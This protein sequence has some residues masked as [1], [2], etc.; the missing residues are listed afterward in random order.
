MIFKT[1]NSEMVARVFFNGYFFGSIFLSLIALYGFVS[2]AG[3]LSTLS[4][5]MYLV[6]ASSLSLNKKFRRCNFSI[7]LC[8]FTLLYLNIPAA[9]ILFEGSDYIFGGGLGSIPFAQS[10]YQ[11]S[12]PLVFLYLSVLWFAIWLGIISVGTKAKKNNLNYFSFLSLTSILLVGVI[13]LIVT[14]IDNQA[15]FDVILKD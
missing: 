12:L 15:F 7:L 8:F 3:I 4:G 6:I 14:W 11:Q 1:Y 10:E 2:G 9:F 5:F 13:V